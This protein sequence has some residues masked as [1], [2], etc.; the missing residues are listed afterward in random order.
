M[1]GRL[2]HDSINSPFKETIENIILHF[3]TA[4][5]MDFKKKEDPTSL[6]HIKI[7]RAFLSIIGA[8]PTEVFEKQA[9]RKILSKVLILAPCMIGV[10][11]MSY[12]AQNFHIFT[13]FDLGDVCM[14]MFLTIVTFVRSLLPTMKKYGL[15]TKA[16]IVEFH[17]VHFKH[18][19]DY[20]EKI[21]NKI[22][23][24]SHYFTL[25]MVTNMIVGPTLFTL[26]PLYNNYLNG[27]FAK[28]KTE[29]LKLQFSV[30][31]SFPGFNQQDHHISSSFIN[32]VL[33]GI[34]SIFVCGIEILI[35]LMAFQIIGHIK[36]LI[37]DLQQV[38]RPKFPTVI[39]VFWCRKNTRYNLYLESYNSMENKLIRQEIVK[40]VEHHRFIVKL[41]SIYSTKYNHIFDLALN[42]RF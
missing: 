25:S 13:F 36:L 26:V 33:G 40:L 27:A 15:L 6:K 11:E 35:Y 22:N 1:I 32:Y 20:H 39:N 10:G 14:T 19:G 7:L 29:N 31:F 37:H 4:F 34:C 30:Y 41:V 9:Q 12:I 5:K 16:F 21:Y 38:P 18:K 24:L 28:N 42:F 23:Y 17:L 3:R 2:F 8:W